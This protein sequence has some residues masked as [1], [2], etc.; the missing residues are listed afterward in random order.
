MEK[1]T[2][3]NVIGIDP[4]RFW[5][6]GEGYWREDGKVFRDAVLVVLDK[7]EAC[8]VAVSCGQI[9]FLHVDTEHPEPNGY[10]LELPEE[11]LSNLFQQEKISGYT[12]FQ[13]RTLDGIPQCFTVLDREEAKGLT[14]VAKDMKPTYYEFVYVKKP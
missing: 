13:H 2:K 6:D 3:F 8:W 1:V 5:V 7:E 12:V 14:D 9:C 10:L 11:T 4:S